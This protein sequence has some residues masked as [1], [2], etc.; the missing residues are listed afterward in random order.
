[1]GIQVTAAAAATAATTT[2][3]KII[4]GDF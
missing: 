4:V 2:A 1:L 3:V